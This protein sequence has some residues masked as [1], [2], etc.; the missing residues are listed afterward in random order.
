MCGL[1][2]TKRSFIVIS[3]TFRKVSLE[4]IK[5]VILCS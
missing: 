1:P 4:R 2:P 5:E 3:L